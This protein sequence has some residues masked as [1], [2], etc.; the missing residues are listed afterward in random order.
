MNPA[1]IAVDGDIASRCEDIGRNLHTPPC[2][3]NR[4]GTGI[5][6]YGTRHV[7]KTVSGIAIHGQPAGG[8]NARVDGVNMSI[9]DTDPLAADARA[10]AIKDARSHAEQFAKAAG[11]NVGQVESISESVVSGAPIPM[12]ST[13]GAAMDTKASYVP[14]QAGTQDVTIQVTVVYAL[15]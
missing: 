6:R 1:A 11:A 12:Y 8:N 7:N 13:A 14:I 2:E 5:V 15:A 9:D 3:R 10:A 4:A